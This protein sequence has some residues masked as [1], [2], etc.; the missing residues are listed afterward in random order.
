MSYI[1][2]D[3]KTVHLQWDTDF[4]PPYCGGNTR[5]FRC[6]TSAFYGYNTTGTS[7]I[8]GDLGLG[9]TFINIPEFPRPVP[10]PESRVI[11][12]SDMVAVGDGPNILSPYYNSDWAY[13]VGGIYSIHNQGANA[14]FC[15]GH[16]EYGKVF[17]WV[18]TDD[19]HRR[20]WNNDHEPH[21]ESW[22]K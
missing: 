13:V 21:P 2:S 15:D 3:N 18:K 11:M 9:G 7:D 1:T 19:V 8:Q 14:V 5:L 22:Y 4:L 12:P 6:P 20:R 17:N 16:V 10:L